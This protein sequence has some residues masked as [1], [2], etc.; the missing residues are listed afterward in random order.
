MG[1]NTINSPILSHPAPWPILPPTSVIRPTEP[2]GGCGQA[3]PLSLIPGAHLLKP[4]EEAKPLA[5]MW[6]S[7]NVIHRYGH[8]WSS[9][10]VIHG[11]GHIKCSQ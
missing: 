2:K 9:V 1:I 11:Y 8:L 5:I 3:L 10:N 7:V 4:S 6:S